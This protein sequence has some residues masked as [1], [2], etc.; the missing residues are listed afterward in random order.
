MVREYK[1]DPNLPDRKKQE[2]VYLAS[3]DKLTHG[4]PEW[5][6]KEVQQQKRNFLK[7][8][9]TTHFPNLTCKALSMNLKQ[10]E[11]WMRTDHTFAEAVVEIQSR[12][13]ERVSLELMKK[14]F[15]DKDI[16][17]MM[18]LHK[19]VPKVAWQS[20]LAGDT[21][22]KTQGMD[23]SK[24]TLEEQE[25]FL[26]LMRK[27]SE[28]NDAH[29]PRIFDEVEDF[30]AVTYESSMEREFIENEVNELIDGTTETNVRII[31]GYDD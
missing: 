4:D 29:T 19:Q 18:F 21:A 6:A 2:E 9:E 7:T 30:P 25:T 8:L 14:A 31:E 20:D 24:L 27:A 13:G 15:G 17:A 11:G 26:T 16:G 22:T 3:L 1:I 23:V 12:L 28:A 5:R 10:V